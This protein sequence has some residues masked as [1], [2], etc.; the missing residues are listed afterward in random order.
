MSDWMLLERVP[1]W[2]WCLVACM[3]ATNLLNQAMCLVSY[4]RIMIAIEMASKVGTFYIVVVWIV[5]VSSGFGYSP[6]HAALDNAKC[7][8]SMPPHGHRNGLQLRCICLLPPPLLGHAALDNAKCIA[9]MPPHGHRNGLRLRCIC[10]LP[11]PLL[12]HD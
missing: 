10:L 3:N 8:A 11:P 6:G 12:G 5:A 7:I 4:S 1:A 2:L 9:S